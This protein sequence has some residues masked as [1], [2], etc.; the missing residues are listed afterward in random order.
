MKN[1]Y[2]IFTTDKWHSNE[3]KTIEYVTDNFQK[4][5]ELIAEIS[6]ERY[7]KELSKSDLYMLKNKK[8]TQ[9]FDEEIEYMIEEYKVI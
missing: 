7:R 4:A 1:A 2:I 9:G 5:I 3:S 8:Q 6:R